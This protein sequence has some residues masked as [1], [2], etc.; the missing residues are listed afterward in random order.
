MA[1]L[2]QLYNTAFID[3]EFHFLFISPGRKKAFEDLLGVFGDQQVWIW[4]DKSNNR[5]Q[6]TI[7]TLPSISFCKLVS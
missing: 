3:V 6:I 1:A 4:D 2:R 7:V 5:L